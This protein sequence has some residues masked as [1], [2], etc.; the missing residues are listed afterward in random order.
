MCDN[1][2]CKIEWFHFG[3]VKLNAK[4]KGKWYC[5]ECRGDT[6]K[7]MKKVSHHTGAQSSPSYFSTSSIALTTTTTLPSSSTNATSSGGGGGGSSSTS[8][9]LNTTS[10]NLS[11]NK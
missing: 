11:R 10:S 9:Q 6:H 2:A 4:P 5:P 7:V 3:C 1:D 8:N